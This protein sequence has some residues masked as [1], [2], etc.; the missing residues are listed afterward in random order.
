MLFPPPRHAGQDRLTITC[1]KHTFNFLRKEGFTFLVVADEAFGR[2]IPFAFLER[3]SEDFLNQHATK[4]RTAAPHS[5]D[6]AFGPKLKQH[7]VSNGGPTRAQ[8]HTQAHVL[9]APNQGRS[10]KHPLCGVAV[11]ALCRTTA[12][13]TQTRF[14]GLQ[15]LGSRSRTSRA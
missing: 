1:D 11:C 7:M 2:Q 14:P 15:P 12:Q 13:T 9:L 3:V 8:Q 4:G 6:R 10:S 5:L